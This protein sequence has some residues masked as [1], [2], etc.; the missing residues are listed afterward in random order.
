MDLFKKKKS[1]GQEEKKSERQEEKSQIVEEEVKT[2]KQEE[3]IFND[4]D[5]SEILHYLKEFLRL[6]QKLDKQKEILEKHVHQL[7][8]KIDEVDNLIS[9]L[10]DQKRSLYGDLE[11]KRDQ[12]SKI[13]ETKMLLQKVTSEN[14]TSLEMMPQN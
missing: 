1:E 11:K 12:I 14:S 2:E 4:V 10:E 6:L 8:Q 7:Q 9:K 3:E 5:A 13:N